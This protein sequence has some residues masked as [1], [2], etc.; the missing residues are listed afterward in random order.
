MT[1]RHEQAPVRR[2]TTRAGGQECGG[3]PRY[4]ENYGRRRARLIAC[5]QW[6]PWV[7]ATPVRDHLRDLRRRGASIRAIARAAGVSPA[8]VHRL[9]SDDLSR[10]AMP[11][12]MRAAEARRLLAL[13]HGAASRAAARR[14]AAGTRLRLRALTAV[15]Y[16]ATSLAAHAGVAVCTVRRLIDGSA[17]TVSP[18]LHRAVAAMYD[19]LWD[20]SPASA[21]GAQPRAAA[22]ARERAARNGWP[23][24]MGLDDDRIDDPGYRPR[25]GW[26]PVAPACAGPRQASRAGSATRAGCAAARPARPRP[27]RHD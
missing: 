27:L 5:G 7:P 3:A 19:E 16:P 15:G 9:L 26:R 17:V 22:A 4:S 21:T 14:D 13:S 11:R 8:T 6:Q 20:Q 24:P 25:A 12:R 18:A 10:P 2:D 23:P 1:P